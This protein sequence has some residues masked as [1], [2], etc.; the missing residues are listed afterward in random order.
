[1]N[2]CNSLPAPDLLDDSSPIPDVHDIANCAPCRIP[3]AKS[4][5]EAKR[6]L[7]RFHSQLALIEQALEEAET[8]LSKSSKT[9][10]RVFGE[11]GQEVVFPL[12][13]DLDGQ[14]NGKSARS[15]FA[16]PKSKVQEAYP[17]GM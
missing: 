2:I 16:T 11:P 10:R 9:W 8:D 6:V 13:E 15:P 5:D 3:I 17:F 14:E 1:M 4:I 12:P 7:S